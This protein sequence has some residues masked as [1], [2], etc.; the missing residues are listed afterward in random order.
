MKLRRATDALSFPVHTVGSPSIVCALAVFGSLA[1]YGGPLAGMAAAASLLL[2]RALRVIA[3][4]NEAHRAL[5]LVNEKLNASLR[6]ARQDHEALNVEASRAANEAAQSARAAASDEHARALTRI[7]RAIVPPIRALNDGVILSDAASVPLA[8]RQASRA[9]RVHRCA[10]QT[11]A[12][13][14]HDALDTLPPEKREIIL[15]EDAVDLRE[16]FDAAVLLLAPIA[17]ARRMRMQVCVDRSV[18]ACVLA[19]RAR[20][21]QILFGLLAY[22]IEEAGEGT[23]S[24]AARAESLNAGA[25]RIVIGINGPACATST[26]GDACKGRSVA[27]P[28]AESADF[29]EHPDLALCRAIARRMGGD[30]TV[31]QGRTIGVCAAIHAP[32]T[33]ERH[34]WPILEHERRWAT[35]DLDTYEDRQALCELLKKLGITTLPADAKPPVRIDY[36]FAG[37][38]RPPAPHGAKH[39][40]AMTRD[41]LPGG[42]RETGDVVELSLSPL[43]WTALRHVCDTRDETLPAP[44]VPLR[45]RTRPSSGPATVLVTDDNE[46]NRKVLAR[47]LDVLGYRCIAASSGDE[48]LDVLG[49]ECVDLLITDLQMPGMNGVELARHVNAMSSASRERLPIILLSANPDTT[50][51]SGSDRALF[52]AVLVK[53]ASLNTLDGCLR[54]LLPKHAHVRPAPPA[55]RLE[56]YDYTSLD[57]LA[58]QGVNVGGLL[59]EWHKSMDDDLARLEQCRASGDAQGVR[60]ALHKLAGAIGIVGGR[61]LMN[62]LQQASAAEPP[63]DDG[64]L[65]GLVDRMKA[66]M[67]EL[68]RSRSRWTARP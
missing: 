50:L 29:H 51:T 38:S 30:I 27:H 63:V 20:V 17:A 56:A 49:R 14:A 15:D 59:R 32:F 24:V 12:Q 41:A 21:G 58:E 60:S 1:A 23:L 6:V 43:S 31:L 22:A 28:A 16:L 39:T 48:A 7:Y 13:I 52:G 62:A 36:H 42:M 64:L 61:G 10:A 18:A 53:T 26:A 65:H 4:K 46:V 11:L 40:I 54:R 5:E 67:I 25:Q 47:Q 45:A 57:A 37:T 55:Q 44:A 3:G 35:V 8:A 68:D 9:A 33:I 34:D 19:D 66:L 2:A